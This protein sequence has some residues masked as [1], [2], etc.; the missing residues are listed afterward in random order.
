MSS[1]TAP[2]R[3]DVPPGRR[4]HLPRFLRAYALPRWRWYVAGSAAVL[5]TNWMSVRVPVEMAAGLDALRAGQPGVASAAAH[6][7]LLGIGVIVFRTLSR[8]WFFTPGRLVEFDLREDM[9]ARALRLQPGFYAGY[10]TGDLLTRLT[11]DV[12]FA[13]AF[14]GFALLQLV[15]VV[16]ALVMSLGQML[17]MS[18]LLTGLCALPIAVG[19]AVVQRGTRQSFGLQRQVQTQLG[20]LSDELLG[21]LQGVAT[22]QAFDVEDVFVR[23][24]EARAGDLRATNLALARLRALVFPLLTVAAGVCVYLLLAVGGPMALHGDGIT[25]GELAAF[26]ALLAYLLVPLRLL[27]V[28]VP[29]F[30]RAEASLERIHAVLDAPIERPE[31]DSPVA[32]PSAGRGPTI[33]VRGLTFHHAPAKPA[34]GAEGAHAAPSRPPLDGGLRGRGRSLAAPGAASPSGEHSLPTLA[35][36]GRFAANGDGVPSATPPPVLDDL[37]FTLRAGTTT[38]VYGATGAGKTTL[39][40]VLARLSNPPAGTVFVDGVDV[41]ALDLAEWRTRMMLVP[42]APFLLGESIRENIGFGASDEAVL[43][44]ARAAQLTPDLQALPD[45]LDTVVGERGVVLS[46]GQRQRV[47]LARALLR[48]AEVV[49]LDDVLSA[50]DHTTEQ[51]LVRMLRSRGTEGSTVRAPTRVI[52]SHRMSA[53][54][55]AEQILVLDGGRLVDTGTHGELLARPGPYRDGWEAQHA[56]VPCREPASGEVA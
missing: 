23:R 51:E 20:A 4:V 34:L 45:G 46:G 37:T 14:A 39:L 30:Q 22:I 47:A 54:E 28:M 25:A 27:G 31:G 29:V 2:T 8:V 26:V 1:R 41:T 16:A 11:S 6:I 17:A 50:V 19:F 13:R 42:Q 36:S 55:H 44:A 32:Y 7:A 53:L 3:T 48:E 56:T 38:G 10:P 35:A 49:L 43:A 21:D 52:V 33:E 24:L 12:T 5:L 9:F 40:R 15:N 18:P